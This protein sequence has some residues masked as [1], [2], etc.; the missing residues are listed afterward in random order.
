M[1]IRPMSPEHLP[2]IAPLVRP[3]FEEL[4]LDEDYLNANLFEDPDFEPDLCLGWFEGIE[5]V[6]MAM[7]VPRRSADS[8]TG[9]IGHV[10]VLHS[11][12]NPRSRA[13]LGELLDR[14]ER[15]L[16][17]HG[18]SRVQTDG[19]APVYLLPGLPRRRHSTRAL[20][21]RAGYRIVDKRRS[22]TV[23]L[24][25]ADL[26]TETTPHGPG[27]GEIVFR[28]GEEYD[29]AVIPAQVRSA[30][31]ENFAFEV[32]LALNDSSQGRVHLALCGDQLAG[33]SVAGLWAANAFGPLGTVPDFEGRGV[34][35]VLLKRALRDLR[36]GGISVGVISWVGPERF[37]RSTVNAETTLEY[38]LLE[39]PLVLPVTPTK[40]IP[41][42]SEELV[43]LIDRDDRVIGRTSRRQVR[44]ENRLHRGVGILCMN[45]EGLIYVHKRTDTKDVFPGM[46]DMF[47]GGVVGAGENYDEAARREIA[48]ELGIVGP[49]PE[50]LFRHLYW[51]PQNR[52]LVAVYEVEWDG[53]IRHQ[54]SEIVWGQFLAFDEL[55]EKLEEWTFVPDGL[56]I[57]EAYRAI[58]KARSNDGK[59][60]TG[61]S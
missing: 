19:A 32:E 18:S 14:T 29:R 45:P 31:S 47:V 60:A 16:R 11:Q 35:A 4:G 23:E 43:D 15:T 57:F 34:G 58:K 48:E 27:G 51:G 44:A 13:R 10:K 2:R 53:P 3:D 21:E 20:L 26:D 5:L 17:S 40:D 50:C 54:E 8:T 12:D 30:F 55:L 9:P 39:K 61:S 1:P 7:A 37:Y 28:R 52:S 46:Y 49:S 36:A 6:A 42:P 38:D 25:R 24:S 56:E 22:M 59:G 33:F 41:S